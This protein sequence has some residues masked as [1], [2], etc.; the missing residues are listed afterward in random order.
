MLSTLAQRASNAASTSPARSKQVN[1][2]SRW[3]TSSMRREARR[4]SSAAR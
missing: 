2:A 3:P 1:A 4:A